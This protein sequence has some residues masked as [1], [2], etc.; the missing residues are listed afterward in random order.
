MYEGRRGDI[1]LSNPNE[2]AGA[3]PVGVELNKLVLSTSWHILNTEALT[4]S[5]KDAPASTC[6]ADAVGSVH[7]DA[8]V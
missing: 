2:L 4:P 7:D 6:D 8:E 5:G 1:S 3:L